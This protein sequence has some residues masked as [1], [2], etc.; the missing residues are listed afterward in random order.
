MVIREVIG[1][2]LLD[3]IHKLKGS[4]GLSLYQTSSDRTV[5]IFLRHFG[6]IFCRETLKHIANVRREL[7][8]KGFR[9]ALVHQSDPVYG[10]Y[11]LNKFGLGDII[12]FSDPDLHLYKSFGLKEGRIKQLLGPKVWKGGFRA[13]V[14]SKVIFGKNKGNIY[15]L[16]GFF[17]YDSGRIIASYK[18]R[19]AADFPNLVDFAEGKFSTEET[20]FSVSA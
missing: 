20:N 18:S 6:C 5:V 7:E 16:S 15:Q 14:K 17:V 12:H 11:Y 2:V 1:E 4:H 13:V 8:K 10:T 3:P 19:D 9:I